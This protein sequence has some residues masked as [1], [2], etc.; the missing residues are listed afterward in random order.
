[1]RTYLIV[2]AV[3]CGLYY[4]FTRH[5]EFHDTLALAKSH[6][7]AHWAPSVDY[8]V[9]LCYYQ[10]ADWPNAQEAFTQLLTDYPTSHYTPKALVYLDDAAE[11]NH[12]WD[13]SKAALSR[14]LEEFPDGK[15]YE[16]MQKR[17]EMVK[18]Q[19]P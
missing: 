14:Y 17:M 12:D 15:D 9:G 11:Y 8:Y 1:M 6:P 3:I 13:T 7:A 19:H 5:F 10:R 4:F 16:V 2:V 18:Y